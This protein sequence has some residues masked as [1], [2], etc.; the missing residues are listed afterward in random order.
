MDVT[1]HTVRLCPQT[2]N[3]GEEKV[4]NNVFNKGCDYEMMGGSL[5]ACFKLGK[6]H[7]NAFPRLKE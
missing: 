6:S 4:T 3:H 5:M 1:V 2:L 7:K